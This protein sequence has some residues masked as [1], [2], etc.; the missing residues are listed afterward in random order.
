[1][2]IIIANWKMNLNVPQSSAY[3]VKLSETVIPNESAEIV[4]CP[5]FLALQTLHLQND[6]GKFKLGAQNCNALDDGALTG[7][8]SA[9]MLVGVADYIIIGHSER[10]QNFSETDHDVNQKIKAA[11]RHGLRPIL[12]I[13]ERKNESVEEVLQ[14]QLNGGLSGVRPD[15]IDQ[16]IIAY[17]PISAIGSGQTPTMDEIAHA[18]QIIRAHI[19]AMFGTGANVKLAYG[20]SVDD[21]NVADIL[22]IKGIN[23]LLVGGASL[24]AVK[25]VRIV[26]EVKIAGEK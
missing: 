7:E 11:L 3:F 19:F 25:F 1:M 16:I 23:G 14:T 21:S 8:V 18:I 4:L 10:R 24:D 22:D 2:T 20:G 15:Q 26:E 13:G 5:T 17:E 9:G 12:C 6:L